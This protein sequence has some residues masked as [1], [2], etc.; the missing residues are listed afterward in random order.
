[1]SENINNPDICL[2]MDSYGEKQGQNPNQRKF[3]G[4]VRKKKREQTLFDIF[5]TV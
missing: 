4:P 1:M 2:N 5:I 3:L